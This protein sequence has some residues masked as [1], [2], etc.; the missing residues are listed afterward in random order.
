[1]FFCKDLDGLQLLE[2]LNSP[3]PGNEDGLVDGLVDG[4]N[5]KRLLDFHELLF[6]SKHLELFFLDCELFILW[7]T[8]FLKL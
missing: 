8:L 7:N 6:S 4:L 2:L 3:A 1:M 5:H